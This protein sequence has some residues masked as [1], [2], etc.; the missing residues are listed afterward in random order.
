MA[1]ELVER[2]LPKPSD[3]GYVEARLLEALAILG[4]S[5]LVDDT[6]QRVGQCPRPSVCHYGYSNLNRQEL[7]CLIMF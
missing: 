2:L 1:V 4:F 6:R 7:L 3:E 5:R